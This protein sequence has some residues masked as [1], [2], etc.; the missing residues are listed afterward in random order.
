MPTSLCIYV[1]VLFAKK[2]YNWFLCTSGVKIRNCRGFGGEPYER[3]LHSFV[4]ING[5]LSAEIIFGTKVDD[6]L[7][8]EAWRRKSKY[9]WELNF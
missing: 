9:F 5:D 6:R 3:F 8:M 4:D 7:K 1:F 2:V